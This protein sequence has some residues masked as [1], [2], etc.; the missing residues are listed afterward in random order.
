MDLG[1]GAGC[2]VSEF[3]LRD[4]TNG[5]EIDPGA[6]LGI[7]CLRDGTNGIEIDPGADLGMRWDA[8]IW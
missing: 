2:Y 6:D 1:M 3:C 4:G 7:S 8:C 5:I